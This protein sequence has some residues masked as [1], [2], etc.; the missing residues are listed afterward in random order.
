M[1]LLFAMDPILET[2]N[3]LPANPAL[4]YGKPYLVGY[5]GNMSD[6]DGLDILLDVALHIKNLGRRDIHFTC[7]G[8]GP[9]LAGLRK[10]V[11]EKNLDDTVNFTGRVPFHDIVG[12]P[13]NSRHLRES[14]QTV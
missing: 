11:K 14:G 5:V 1:C 3:P 13:I 2:F 8:G 7:V 4:K 9:G 10:M 6:Q 12:D